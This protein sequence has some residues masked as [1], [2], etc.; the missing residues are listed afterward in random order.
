MNP[1][2]QQISSLSERFV[3]LLESE[4]VSQTPTHVRRM[5]LPFRSI[6][7]WVSGFMLSSEGLDGLLVS[8]AGL[9]HP[10]SVNVNLV[11]YGFTCAFWLGHRTG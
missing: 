2:P 10:A 1:K 9:A 4:A 6:C 3:E 7:T 5:H 8:G 11:L